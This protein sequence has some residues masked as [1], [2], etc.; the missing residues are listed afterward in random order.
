MEKILPELILD[1]LIEINRRLELL[2]QIGLGRH[3]DQIE[4]RKRIF[5]LAESQSDASPQPPQSSV[6]ATS[7]KPDQAEG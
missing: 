4:G 1:E 7:A 2:I 3:P 6:S 5:P